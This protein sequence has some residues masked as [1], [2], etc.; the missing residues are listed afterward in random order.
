MRSWPHTCPPQVMENALITQKSKSS[1]INMLRAVE[2]MIFPDKHT[3]IIHYRV[4]ILLFSI[5]MN[6]AFFHI[7]PS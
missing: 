3:K 4:G 7:I 2:Q 6:T 5:N 1:D